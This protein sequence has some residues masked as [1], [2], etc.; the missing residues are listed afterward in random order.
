MNH[1]DAIQW[2]YDWMVQRRERLLQ[3]EKQ[4]KEEEA[5]KVRELRERQEK[6]RVDRLLSEVSTLKQATIIR[7]Y[8]EVA[9]AHSEGLSISNEEID[10]WSCWAL[11][12]AD[13]IDPLKNLVFLDSIKDEMFGD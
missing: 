3:E 10:R 9:R 13:R 2:H 7:E 1:R 5:G 8:V 11:R 6:E 12:Q 4:R